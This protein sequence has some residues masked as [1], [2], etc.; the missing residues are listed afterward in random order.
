MKGN[1]PWTNTEHTTFVEAYDHIR[2]LKQDKEETICDG[3]PPIFVEL[4]KYVRNIDFT[5][6]P[7]YEYMR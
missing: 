5:V 6:K 3:C 4:L 2:T 1:L 7:D